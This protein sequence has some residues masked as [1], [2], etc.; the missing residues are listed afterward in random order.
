MSNNIQTVA[1]SPYSKFHNNT[2][3]IGANCT[4]ESL[5][6]NSSE[7]QPFIIS[8]Y[9]SYDDIA[10]ASDYCWKTSLFLIRVLSKQLNY[11]LNQ[12]RSIE[13]WEG[14]LLPWLF[15]FIQNC[16]DRYLRLVWVRENSP[17]AILE[18]PQI[19]LSIPSLYKESDDVMG[20]SHLHSINACI[21]SFLIEEMCLQ[22]KVS[23][24]NAVVKD[25]DTYPKVNFNYR[26]R[27]FKESILRHTPYGKMNYFQEADI[28]IT[29]FKNYTVKTSGYAKQALDRESL[30]LE[31]DRDE[32]CKIIGHVIPKVFPISLFEEYDDRSTYA[33]RLITKKKIKTFCISN[34][35][36]GNDTIKYILSELRES[37]DYIVGRQHGGGYGVD[38]IN[39]TELVER[40]LSDLFITWGWKDNRSGQ[41]LALPDP[42]LSALSNTHKE[43]NDDILYI[44][45]H[46]PMYMFRHQSYWM[47]EFVYEQYCPMQGEFIRTLNESVRPRFLYRPFP[48]EYGWCEKERIRRFLPD[49]RF[50]LTSHTAVK[51]LKKL[52]SCSI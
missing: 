49:V 50:D 51:T 46:G 5:G 48:H 7:H 34:T 42:R 10:E 44:G 35:F 33:Q 11:I 30:S 23:F 29:E 21:Y 41:T 52:C 2:I 38:D 16:H 28:N 4:D 37:G 15:A 31:Q 32:F 40:Y 47:P 24:L 18:L 25:T 19:S 9:N 20:K 39:S 27:M 14:L 26:K 8:P 12:N 36:W 3:L 13:Y 1:L 17:N 43:M 45:T 22:D 6:V